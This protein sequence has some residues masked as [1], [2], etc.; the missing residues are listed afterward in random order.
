MDPA[1]EETARSLG[2]GAWRTFLRVVMP[3]LR[4]A[5]LGGML[6]VLLDTLVEFDAFVALKFQ[7]FGQHLRPVPAELQRV[8]RGGA[9]AVL[10]R[11]VRDRP[12]RRVAAARRGELHADQPGRAAAGSSATARPGA[13]RLRSSGSRWWRRSASGSRS[14][15]VHWFTEE[16]RTAG[17]GAPRASGRVVGDAHHGAARGRLRRWSRSCSRCRSRSSPS[18]AGQAR[19]DARAQRLPVVRAARPGRGDRARVRGQPRRPLPL[20][21]RGAAGAGRGDA[22]RPVRGRRTAEH[23]RADRAG[24]RGVRA[25]AR[26]RAA[27][28]LW[29]VTV[30]LARPGLAAA[31]VLVFAFVLGDLSTAQV[32]LPP[33]LTTLGTSSGP[34]ADGRVRRR[35]SLRGGARSSWRWSP[36]TC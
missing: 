35:G 8:G 30:P 22:V 24:A 14:A 19:D 31:G 11:R 23:D 25:L 27:A 12:V 4:P 32:L 33:G 2:L 6:L 15:L 3:Q 1:L 21:D 16:Q 5:L 20:R 34:T 36:R 26:A 9:V 17:A 13:R 28:D 29:R 18:G 10:D 7:T